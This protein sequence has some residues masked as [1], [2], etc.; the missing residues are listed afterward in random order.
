MLNIAITGPESTGKSELTAY[1][2]DYFDA[3]FSEEYAREYLE[4]QNGKYHVEDLNE[5]AIEQQQRWNNLKKAPLAF[6]DTEMLVLNIWSMVKF[7]KVSS[8]I[9]NALENQYFD[10]YLLCKPDIPWAPDPLRESQDVRDQ[11]FEMYVALLKEKNFPF[12]V[13][14]GS[15][16]NREQSAVRIVEDLLLTKNAKCF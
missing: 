9:Q 14:S 10:H 8:I 13:I 1:L 16:F 2:A 12:T 3:P 5:I 7:G 4:E 15:F 6:Y 11:L